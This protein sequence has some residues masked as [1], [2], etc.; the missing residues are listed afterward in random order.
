M[1]ADWLQWAEILQDQQNKLFWD[2]KSFGY[3]TSSEGD[4][5]ILIR[6]KEGKK[7]NNFH[8]YITV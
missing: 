4:S 5:S 7:T 3:F 2:D 1:D 6:G 8:V